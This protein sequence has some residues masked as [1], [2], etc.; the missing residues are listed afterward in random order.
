LVR[1]TRPAYTNHEFIK[2]YISYGAGPR[3]SQY[4]I[5]GAKS[6]AAINGKYTPDIDDVKAV[7]L[8][9]L[10]HRIVTNFSA[11]AE[12]L[13]GTKLIQMLLDKN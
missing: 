7:A 8:P 10:R 6:R 2:N 9:V 13:D 5:L 12:N 4:L 3:A 11:E 1:S